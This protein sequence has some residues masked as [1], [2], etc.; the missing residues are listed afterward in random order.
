MRH[1]Q[2]SP[3]FYLADR[4]AFADAAS[5]MTQFGE[6]AGNE[7][8]VRADRS[9]VAGNVVHFCHWRQIERAIRALRDPDVTGTVH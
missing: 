4:T 9:R 3:D 8:A 5:L 1:C 6:G 7:A 2:P